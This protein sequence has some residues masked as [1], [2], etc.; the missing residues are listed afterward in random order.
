MIT[1]PV[2][3]AAILKKLAAEKVRLGSLPIQK[4]RRML[5]T[6][7][8]S[9]DP[10]KPMVW[11]NEVCW[12]EMNV[13]D[14]LTLQT[15]HPFARELE[16]GLRRELY[17]WHHMQGDMIVQPVM[18]CPAVVHNSGFGITADEDIARTDTTASVVSHHFHPQIKT[19]RDIEKILAPII[20]YDVQATEERLHV[21]QTLFADVIPV[22]V[23]GQR[24]FWFAPWDELV[25]WTGVQE[26]LMDLVLR[27]DY[28]HAL[29]DRL[30]SVYCHMLD[31]FEDQ[32]LLASNNFSCRVGSGG[33]GY[34]ADLPGNYDRVSVVLSDNEVQ[35]TPAALWGCATAQIFSDVSPE[36]HEEFALRYELRWLNRFG[37]NYY[38]CCESLHNK[39]PIL[40]RIPNLRKVSISPWC[41]IEKARENGADAYVLSIKPSPALLAGDGW[42]PDQVRT[43]LK[44]LLSQARGCS[45][46]IIMKDISTVRYQPQRLWEWARIA[47]ETAESF[48]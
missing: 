25:R 23:C 42:H 9:N 30:V 1:I 33:Y 18:Y 29:I 7:L 19:E 48:V 12:N 36:M 3:D 4:E 34:T 39:L 43:E 10:V 31:Q 40:K 28:V 21:M 6:R 13:N 27:P 14:E 46:E 41:S 45:I 24:G 26:I 22:N 8:N 15:S 20:A 2:K 17:Q 44:N 32:N 11:L 5:W 47:S 35:G 37:L 38:G 16:T